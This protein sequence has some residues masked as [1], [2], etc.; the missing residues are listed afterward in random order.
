[1]LVTGLLVLDTAGQDSFSAM[2]QQYMR[3]GDGFLIMFSITDRNSFQMVRQLYKD[4]LRTK[5]RDSFPVLMVGNKID[6][7]DE[8]KV[9]EMEAKEL[10]VE[11]NVSR[12]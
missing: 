11:L 12:E 10:A 6:M 8:R 2:R 7:A 9:T 1:M 3:K 4:I 5:D